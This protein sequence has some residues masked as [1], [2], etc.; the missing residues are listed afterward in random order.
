[1]GT[2]DEGSNDSDD[3]AA[4]YSRRAGPSDGRAFDNL[5]GDLG[6]LCALRSARSGSR[7]RARRQLWEAARWWLR[8]IRYSRWLRDLWQARLAR[9]WYRDRRVT[10]HRRRGSR[11]AGACCRSGFPLHPFHEVI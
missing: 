8:N 1:G 2:D 11:L 7:S 6:A 9:L 10:R 3:K 4:R 5:G